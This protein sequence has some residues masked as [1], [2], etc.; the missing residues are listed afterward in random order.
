MAD[1]G[2]GECLHQGL[3]AVGDGGLGGRSVGCCEATRGLAAVSIE[4][5]P[6]EVRS[7]YV[8]V[9]VTATVVKQFGVFWHQ[10]SAS[11]VLEK[12]SRWPGGGLDLAGEML[13]GGSDAGHV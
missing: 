10:R 12:T 2:G 3:G 4:N 8:C 1:G 5:P 7:T 13:G 11:I 9:L 6:R